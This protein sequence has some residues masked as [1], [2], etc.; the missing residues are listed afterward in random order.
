MRIVCGATGRV[1]RPRF[2]SPRTPSPHRGQECPRSHRTEALFPLCGLLR[3]SQLAALNDPFECLSF[4]VRVDARQFCEKMVAAGKHDEHWL[5]RAEPHFAFLNANMPDAAIAAATDFLNK[6]VGILSL[7]EDWRSSKMWGYY[8]DKHSGFC[9]GFDPD[10][11]FWGGIANS[12]EYG[13]LCRVT[14]SEKR[15]GRDLTNSDALPI[16]VFSAKSIDW[17]HEKEV[18]AI[19][20]LKDEDA[21][22]YDDLAERVYCKAIPHDAV[23]EIMIG[24]YADAGIMRACLQ[25]G[26]K[27]AIPVYRCQ[28]QLENETFEM[29]RHP[30]DEIPWW[31]ANA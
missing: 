22:G 19:Y 10:H 13:R 16:G 15:G 2:E 1:P 30:F 8:A 14:Y 31:A 28:P 18:R 23:K 11:P 6:R 3:V 24:F 4:Y 12:K 9:I 29:T 21:V 5:L 7:S 25:F 20:E 27:H 26:Q 17:K